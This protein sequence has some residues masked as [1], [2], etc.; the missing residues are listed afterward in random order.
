[1]SIFSRILTGFVIILMIIYFCAVLFER[2]LTEKTVETTISKIEK[3]TSEDGDIYHL[4]YTKNEIFINKDHYFHNKNNSR[5]IQSKLKP[6]GKYK[7]KVVGFNF[8]AEIP[9]FLNYR[10]IL[11]I[12]ESKTFYNV[13]PKDY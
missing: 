1:M 10:N 3:I 4:I 2:S 6:K 9:L 13:T 5:Q 12:V 8:G 11:E 7:F